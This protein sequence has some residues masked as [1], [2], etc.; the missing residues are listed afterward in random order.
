MMPAFACDMTVFSNEERQHHLAMIRQVFGAALGLRELG[1]GYAFRFD[2]DDRMLMLL[3]EFVSG[4]RRCCPFF[5]FR[6][7]VEPGGGPAWLS[8]TGPDGVKPF[9]RA[10]IGGDLPA[11]LSA[12]WE[13]A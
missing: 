7:E 8:L 11:G 1:D 13:V 9:I 10:E 4:E 5:G 3:A 6:I 2:S 12:A